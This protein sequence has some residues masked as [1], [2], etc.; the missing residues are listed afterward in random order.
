MT[1]TV[2]G[3]S[4]LRSEDPGLLDGSARFM[5]DLEI[6]GALHA[7]FVRSHVAHGVVEAVH[8][9][10]AAECDGVHSV[11]TAADLDLPGQRAFSGEEALERPLLAVDR[12]RFVGE[13]VAVVLADTLA[14]ALDAAEA[15]TVEIDPLP[16]VADPVAAAADGAPLLF[17]ATAPTSSVPV[18]ARPDDDFFADAD[19]VVRVLVKHQRVAPVTMEANGCVAVPEADGSLTVWASTQS[20]FGVQGEVARTL[21]LDADRVR[22]RAPWIGGGFGAKGGVYPE[23]LVVAG[24]AHKVGR[25]VRWTESRRENLLGM[26]HGRAQVHDV[27][28][29]ATHDGTF[30]GLRVRGYADVGAYAIRGMFIPM[31]TRMMSSGVYA[32]PKID[33]GVT[34]VVTNTT[35]TGPYRGAGRPEAAA[36]VERAVDTMARALGHRPG[37]VAAAQLP[38]R[39]RVPVHHRDRHH[40]RQR[41]VRGRARRGAAPRRL[42]RPARRAARASCRPRCR[43][44]RNRDRRATWRRRAEAASSGR[45]RCTTTAPSPSSPAACRT[46]RD[47]RRRGRR[48]RRQPSACRSRRSAS[49]TPTPRSSTTASAPSD[50]VP[51]NSPVPPCAKP[52]RSCS[53]RR[54][55]WRRS[56]SRRHPTTSSSSTTAGS[57]SPAFPRAGARGPSSRPRPRAARRRSSHELD[58]DSVGSFPF[59]CHVAVV[60]IDRETGGVTLREIVAVDDCGVVVNPLLAEGQVHGGLAQ[61]VAQILYEGV[62]YDDDGNPLTA[63]LLDYLVPAASDLPAFTTA[64]TVTPSPNNPLGA[65]GIGES[66]TTG[67]IAA[68]W[69]AVLDALAPFGVVDIDPPC[70]PEVVWRA[71]QRRPS[72]GH[73]TEALNRRPLMQGPREAS[74][75]GHRRR[76]P[77]RADR[78][79]RP[80][81]TRSG[82]SAT[83]SRVAPT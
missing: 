6:E 52:P 63:S 28:L 10:A 61:G 77:L 69:N 40:L 64:H 27:E 30:T 53:T 13:A 19:V 66:G 20:V 17:P 83:T 62:R 47:T 48:S 51:R 2:L 7:V 4:V 46:A 76:Q 34:P 56:C 55:H 32:I 24:L 50:H 82:S 37:R 31:V 38:A 42:R 25:P 21:G 59:G 39:F 57:A 41:R 36:L 80:V 23:Q 33:F 11:W 45:S 9:A 78:A 5:A 29:G 74:V 35:P 81:S 26:T 71:M 70:S 44:P 43:A 54:G 67:S 22:V 79:S 58:F 3:H 14:Q 15:V 18:A 16:A 1:R 49:C 65:K 8:T 68:V 72:G 75:A 73:R 60:E 12:V